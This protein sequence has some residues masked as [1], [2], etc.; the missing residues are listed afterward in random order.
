MS[1][2]ISVSVCKGSRLIKDGWVL[3]VP[4]DTTPLALFKL[5]DVPQAAGQVLHVH[6]S[7]GSAAIRQDAELTDEIG[8]RCEFGRRFV[9]YR[10][11]VPGETPS[12]D[13]RER[14]SINAFAAMM[15]VTALKRQRYWIHQEAVQT[16]LRQHW[17]AFSIT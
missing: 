13:R 9:F 4:G 6:T 12:S 17:I 15:D 7:V 5:L 10:L 14:H 8:R 11:D 2:A 1:V 16:A 3:R